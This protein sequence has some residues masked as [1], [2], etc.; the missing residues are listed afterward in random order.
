MVIK[1][2]NIKTTPQIESSD[3]ALDVA[4]LWNNACIVNYHYRSGD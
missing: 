3:K 2:M 4:E 1:Q